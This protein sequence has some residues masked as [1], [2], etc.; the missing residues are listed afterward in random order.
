MGLKTMQVY[1]PHMA[2]FLVLSPLCF[3]GSRAVI[4]F[5]IL[6]LFIVTRTTAAATELFN[7]ST[8]L[9]PGFC[10]SD[11]SLLEPLH[12]CLASFPSDIMS[13]VDPQAVHDFAIEVAKRAGMMIL[14]A[15]A[16]RLNNAESETSEKV[17]CKPLLV[18]R[19]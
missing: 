4:L 19:P 15:S 5:L 17:N 12:T 11:I 13:S 14:E 3:L 8:T 7:Q 16:A 9:N 18:R 10:Y 6:Q 1:T 2:A